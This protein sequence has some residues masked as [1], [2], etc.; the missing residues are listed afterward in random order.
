MLIK[1]P[2]IKTNELLDI[3]KS[4]RFNKLWTLNCSSGEYN[5]IN[6]ALSNR[7][8]SNTKK[9]NIINIKY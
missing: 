9:S 5:I 3:D 1:I 7:P 2:I 4:D 6:K 8:K